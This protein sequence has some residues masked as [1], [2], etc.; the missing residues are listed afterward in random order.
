[1]NSNILKIIEEWQKNLL[2]FSNRNRLINCRIG[3]RNTLEIVYPNLATILQRIVIDEES[4]QFLW[5][6]DLVRKN[7]DGDENSET[8]KMQRIT[9][10]ECVAS[11]SLKES[12]LLTPLS[13][14]E[15][16]GKLKRKSADAKTSME[17]HGLNVLY[18]GFGL[19]K[20]YES[21]HSNQELFS[22]LYLVP[23]RL[24]QHSLGEPWT[25]TRYD[26]EAMYNHSLCE[27]MQKD[28]R[29]TLPL[30]QE[31]E[32]SQ[33]ADFDD[34]LQS[35]RA[36]IPQSTDYDRWEI[37]RRVVLEC[38]NFQK[39]AMY[40]DMGQNKTKIAEHTLCRLIAGDESASN[41]LQ[42]ESNIAADE[43]DE[44]IHP[45]KIFSVLDSDSSQQEA[46]QAVLRGTNLVLDGPPGTGKSQTIA[47]IIAEMLAIDKTV[48]FVSEKTAAI[49]VV[50]KRLDNVQLGDFCLDCHALFKKSAV[51]KKGIVSE[52]TRCLDLGG[53][54]YLDQADDLEELYHLRE[55]LNSY[56]KSLHEPIS[57]LQKTPFQIHGFFLKYQNEKPFCSPIPDP[58]NITPNQLTTIQNYFKDL[59]QN[60]ATKN[61]AAHPWRGCRLTNITFDLPQ[62]KEEFEEL[63]EKLEQ[64]SMAIRILNENDILD[65]GHNY[66]SLYR[67]L[68]KIL[69]VFG[70]AKPE[71]YVTIP[72]SWF[73]KTPEFLLDFLPRLVAFR[74]N[75][76]QLGDEFGSF[77]NDVRV[78]NSFEFYFDN[79][80]FFSEEFDWLQNAERHKILN[81]RFRKPE[82]ETFEGE[83][84]LL[85]R[86]FDQLNVIIDKINQ[87]VNFSLPSEISK[88]FNI[89]DLSLQKQNEIVEWICAVQLLPEILPNWTEQSLDKKIK[90][91]INV[92]LKYHEKAKFYREKSE[93]YEEKTKHLSPM[94]KIEEEVDTI[95]NKINSFDNIFKQILGRIN[96]SFKKWQS[97]L[98]KLYADTI[99]T[100]KQVIVDMKNLQQYHLWHKKLATLETEN[101]G[102][103]VEGGMETYNQTVK[104]RNEMG[105]LFSPEV[106]MSLVRAFTENEHSNI[107]FFSNASDMR[108]LID[109]LFA[110]IESLCQIF[111]VDKIN[112]TEYFK[113][114]SLERYRQFIVEIKNKVEDRLT[115][116]TRILDVFTNQALAHADF[117]EQ[118]RRIEVFLQKLTKLNNEFAV[119]VAESTIAQ[120]FD[121]PELETQ[122]ASWQRFYSAF[123]EKITERNRRILTSKECYKKIDEQ[124]AVVYN[125][126][127]LPQNNRLIKKLLSDY[128]P[129]NETI[130][131]GIVLS[132]SKIQELS[133]WLR[134]R[135]EDIHLMN[136]W[137]RYEKSTEQLK[138]LGFQSFVN[139]IEEETLKTNKL[140]AAFLLKFYKD[141]L[142]AVYSQLPV[143]ADFN[144]DKQS[145]T[146]E[147]FRKYDR[148]LYKEAYKRL[149]Q[150]LLNSYQFS[151][152]NAPPSSDIGILKAESNKKRKLMSIRQLFSKIHGLILKLKP[153]VMMSPLT[154]STYLQNVPEKFDLVIFDEASQ[155]RPHDSVTVIYRGKQLVV[156]GDQKQLPPTT[157]FERLGDDNDN[158]N[159][160]DENNTTNINDFESILDVFATKL[161]RKSLHWH[162]RSRREPL[163]AFSNRHIYDNKLVTFPSIDDEKNNPAVR[164]EF[165]PN[166]RWKSGGSGCFNPIEA[167]KTAQLVFQFFRDHPDKSLG[168]IT[169]N[170]RHQEAVRDA[171]EILRNKFPEMERFFNDDNDDDNGNK[172]ERF[173]VK[174]LENVQGDERDYIFLC[175]GYAKTEEGKMSMNFGALNKQGGERRLNV[176]ITRAKYGITVVSSIKYSDLDLKRTSSV[177]VELLHDY[178]NFVE[179]GISRLAASVA[180]PNPEAEAESP[181][182]QEVANALKREGF[183]VCHQ[184]GCSGYR[185]DL[186]LVDRE[187]PGCYVLG[188]ECDGATYHRSATAR[189]RDRLRQEV[190]EGLGWTIHRIWSTDWIQDPK[191]QIE[192]VKTAFESA[193]IVQK[194]ANCEQNAETDLFRNEKPVPVPKPEDPFTPKYNYTKRNKVPVSLIP[195]TILYVLK[196]QSMIED[197]LFRTVAKIFGFQRISTK[198]RQIFI[199]QLKELQKKQLI[200]ID[201]DSR[202]T[203]SSET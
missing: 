37:Q 26:D 174:N 62:I 197:D 143:L 40:R 68:Q 71:E 203:I 153:C 92:N 58:L 119:M 74:K 42:S 90:E 111:T 195:E 2:D 121:R 84:F 12:D 152:V 87:L 41:S 20:W 149:R 140:E 9:L 15:L 200:T 157:F 110:N 93:Q 23:V 45:L 4:V 89:S 179:Y 76:Q 199:E 3:V 171:I 159:D 16:S 35:I 131:T 193:K 113:N 53:E 52:L 38:F 114:I 78:E 79:P 77:V 166:G 202:F 184:I 104:L 185:I 13:D 190:L 162:Y 132:K 36:A 49:E 33:E 5:K 96:G 51:G 164:C 147:N 115:F 154:V 95:I 172:P 56:A 191:Q 72:E 17:E 192:K 24:Y 189:D 10:E 128:F 103:Y 127:K 32:I 19:L 118:R 146:I 112:K 80:N 18:L 107:S 30:R 141:W 106:S 91:E 161:P 130:S 120:N 7:S 48:L 156:A 6:N 135:A 181:F 124:I 55:Q 105:R 27:R 65:I 98:I 168:V 31:A 66:E 151:S 25:I 59:A 123:E 183:E 186:A 54:Q 39:L 46:I 50:K 108:S 126:Y 139:E 73:D 14:K 187:S 134:D 47:N 167:E 97:E 137:K 22:P 1:M 170:Q 148:K 198:T 117:L 144:A 29:L 158:E 133:Q 188:I 75:Y 176:A 44:K 85:L 100:T 196:H 160:D 83:K 138:Q 67:S 101:I 69:P 175:I 155:V 102:R 163:I 150:K 86:I 173:F 165:V 11:P 81:N 61:I 109:D 70:M 43:L 129:S 182:E 21:V 177:G 60:A 116:L 94:A 63:A 8:D 201:K 64:C 169:L 82:P 34:F 99:P 57:L 178:L 136:D 125:L 28:F 180:L 122:I 142:T 194:S 88:E 145:R